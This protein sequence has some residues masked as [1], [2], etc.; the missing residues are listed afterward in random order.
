MQTRLQ[1]YVEDRTTMTAAIAHDLRT[2]LMRLSVLLDDVPPTTRAAADAEIRE[3]RARISSILSFIKGVSS[4]VKRQRLSLRS[5]LE[6]VVNELADRGA[7]VTLED[8]PDLTIDADV[9]GVRAMLTNLAENAVQYAGSARLTLS[10]GGGL[11]HVCVIDSGPGISPA[12]LDRVFEPFYRVEASR[13]RDT[14][15]S[16]LGLAS[17]RAVARAHGGDITLSNRE[18]G[19]LIVSVSLPC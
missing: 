17:A 4:P 10:G 5:L 6:S 14:G 11:A 12:H 2:P 3:M 19:G 16:G 9:A 18:S 13:N 8:G 7:D 1:R 15:G